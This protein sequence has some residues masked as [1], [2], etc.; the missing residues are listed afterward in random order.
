MG[1]LISIVGAAVLVVALS[2]CAGPIK[3]REIFFYIDRDLSNVRVDVVYPRSPRQL[4]TFTELAESDSWFGS[5]EARGAIRDMVDIE[6]G[7]EWGWF[8]L[9]KKT[10]EQ[11]WMMV[12]AEYPSSMPEDHNPRPGE[13][14]FL[15]FEEPSKA[16]K[17]EYIRVGP[18]YMIRE[19]KKPKDFFWKIARYNRL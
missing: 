10:K 5:A 12:I 7:G 6:E 2:G 18:G 19:R 15:I 14:P 1:R 8:T 17:R 13:E 4:N 16:K 3:T 11:P 9:G